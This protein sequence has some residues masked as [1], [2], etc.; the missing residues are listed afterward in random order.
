MASDYIQLTQTDEPAAGEALPPAGEPQ[1]GEAGHGEGDTHTAVGTAADHGGEHGATFPPFDSSTFASQLVWLAITF[2]LF[3]YLMSKMV[4]P[5]IAQTL[6]QRHDRIASDLAEAERLK[7]ETDEAIAAYEQSLAEARQR[8]NE[9]A[10]STRD[11]VQSSIDA[12]RTEAE[13]ALATRMQEAEAR[14]AEV[15]AQA[16]SNVDEIATEAAAEIVSA[17]GGGKATKAELSKTVA[18]VRA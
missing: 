6:E 3:Y 14:I 17:L 5:R 1:V 16:M 4:L 13:D 2:G 18:D 10:K 8:A 12:E 11:R 9:I 7:S 15:K